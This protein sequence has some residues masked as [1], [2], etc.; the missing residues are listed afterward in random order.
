[1]CILATELNMEVQG[2]VLDSAEFNENSR[3]FF[4]VLK[5]VCQECTV[6]WT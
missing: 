1:M 3:Q 5:Q 6:V 2:S 4:I